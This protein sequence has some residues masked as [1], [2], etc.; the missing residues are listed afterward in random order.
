MRVPDL[1]RPLGYDEILRDLVDKAVALLPGY[2]PAPGDN[3]MLVLQAFAYREKLLRE[4]F[5]AMTRGLFL[6]TATGAYLDNLAETLYGEYRLP[7]AKP[8]ATMEFSTTAPLGYDLTIPAR[9]ELVDEGGI[10]HAKLMHDVT[11]QAGAE[12]ATGTIEL[13]TET[14]TSKAKTE[15]QVSPLPFVQVKQTSEFTDGSDPEDDEKFRDRIRVSLSDKSTAGAR[16]TYISYTLS[17]DERIEDVHVHSPT[18]GVV[19]VVYWSPTMDS[20]MQE[21]VVNALSADDVRPLTDDVQVVAATEVPV[22]ITAKLVIERGRDAAQI[23]SEATERVQAGAISPQIGQDVSLS[24][25]ISLL[26]VPGVVD[27]QL[28]AP[29]GSVTIGNEEIAVLGNLSINYEVTSD[30]Y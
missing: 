19:R 2:R 14:A 13:Q 26:M 7:G 5:D 22:D 30:E 23:V 11:I 10:Y 3:V 8:T 27:V 18:P 12:S 21:R 29:G 24:R 15:I 1:P 17:A 20:V 9:Y 25:I 28:T 6:S 16:N 4:E